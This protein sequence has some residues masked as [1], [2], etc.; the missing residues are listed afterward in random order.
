M[1]GG[2]DTIKSNLKFVKYSKDLFKNFNLAF[3]CNLFALIL[4]IFNAS[5]DISIPIPEEFFN[6]L[7]RLIKIHPQPVPIS[8]KKIFF[9]FELFD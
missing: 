9:F 5:F 3:F 6:S 8:R 2:F 7:I 4:A 1:Y